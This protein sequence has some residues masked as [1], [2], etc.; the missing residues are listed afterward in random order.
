MGVPVTHADFFT[1][2][3]HHRECSRGHRQTA[4]SAEY[5][6]QCGG[7]IATVDDEEPTVAFAQYAAKWDREPRELYAELRDSDEPGVIGL[8]RGELV[9]SNTREDLK[10]VL[11]L[12]TLLSSVSSDHYQRG[13]PIRVDQLP[14]DRVH[15]TAQE[16]GMHDRPVQLIS[17]LYLSI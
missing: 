4:G 6:S 1:V 16:L 10:A 5:C 9:Q 12:G 15:Q 8:F 13:G 11:I 3:G 7:K 17:F 14:I 2:T